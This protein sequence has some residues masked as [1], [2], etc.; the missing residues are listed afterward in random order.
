[1]SFLRTPSGI[2]NLRYFLDVDFVLYVEGGDSPNLEEL[3]A[4]KYSTESQDIHFWRTVFAACSSSVRLAYRAVGSKVTLQYLCRLLINGTVQGSL[5]AMDRDYD[6][7]YGKLITSPF[8]FYTFGHS[9]ETDV[10]SPNVVERLFYSL[11]ASG[12]DKSL[13]TPEIVDLY[14]K[15]RTDSRHAIRADIL[16][17]AHAIEFV[18]SS[19][20]RRLLRTDSS[21]RPLICRTQI[22]DHITAAKSQRKAQIRYPIQEVNPITDCHGHLAA[23]FGYLVLKYLTKKFAKPFNFPKSIMSNW[24]I[25]QFANELRFSQPTPL[26]SHYRDGCVLTGLL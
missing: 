24:A 19:K 25:D 10:W 5:I 9:W 18:P 8:V 16:C 22:K 7:I 26:I 6:H 1:M 17:T 13:L 3:L 14:D 12:V 11:T 4:G 2:S 20:S 23:E 21:E 15:F